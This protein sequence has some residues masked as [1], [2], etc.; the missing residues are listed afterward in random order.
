SATTSVCCT[1]SSTI[2]ES[3]G[4]TSGGATGTTYDRD[5]SEAR[6]TSS[7]SGCAAYGTNYWN[8]GGEVSATTCCQDDAGEYKIVETFGTGMDGSA[9]SSDACCNAANKCTGDG[10]C[11]TSASSYD[12]DNDG[13]TDY[14][15]A[16]TWVDCNTDS[17]C[18][19]GS[20]CS[21]NDCITCQAEHCIGHPNCRDGDICCDDDAECGADRICVSDQLNQDHAQCSY[22]YQCRDVE[23]LAFG[24]LMTTQYSIQAYWSGDSSGNGNCG[25]HAYTV[26]VNPDGDLCLR[27]DGYDADGHVNALFATTDHDTSTGSSSPAS[28]NDLWIYNYIYNASDTASFHQLEIREWDTGF[29]NILYGYYQ[30]E[31][32]ATDG[33]DSTGCCDSSTDCVDDSLQGSATQQYG[34]YDS[35]TC[36]DTGSTVTAAEYCD[37][38][39]WRD[40]DSSQAICQVSGSGCTA[41]IWLSPA[42]KCCGDDGAA[43]DF[44]NA[45]AGNS[46]CINGET[47]IH[48]AG[49]SSR[50][51][52][53]L[54]GE[55]YSCNSGGTFAFDT[56]DGSCARRSAWYCDGSG[57]RA[58]IWK[59]QISNGQTPDDCDGT[60]DSYYGA[61]EAATNYDQE[62]CI[63]NRVR[64][65]HGNGVGNQDGPWRCSIGWYGPY[66]GQCYL[67]QTGASDNFQTIKVSWDMADETPQS[68][69]FV[70]GYRWRVD[71]DGAGTGSCTP[72]I[73]C[74]YDSGCINAQQSVDSNEGTYGDYFNATDLNWGSFTNAPTQETTYYLEIGVEESYPGDIDATEDP[75]SNEGSCTTTASLC[76]PPGYQATADTDCCPLG[77]Q[78]TTYPGKDDDGGNCVKCS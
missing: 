26:P 47:V 12:A 54:N 40:R 5:T 27:Y 4:C 21:G 3:V 45:G 11:K 29:S 76:I 42:A 37:S 58:N 48:N 28:G 13:D 20:F 14:C 30:T 39:I 69:S 64:R 71:N 2:A 68:A 15:N 1:D 53:C 63:D 36:Q 49:D 31:K 67:S 38:G 78:T 55:I 51:Y 57:T 66:I 35:G 25:D 74:Y 24:T 8:I 56:D 65:D 41:Y 72:T 44:E 62:S 9:D 46:C 60:S 73:G 77:S 22:S 43:D 61:D 52:L 19:A 7:A 70:G 34:C 75:N 33:T 32:G 18:P 23:S 17:N 59:S 50:K 10:A 16:G 6:C